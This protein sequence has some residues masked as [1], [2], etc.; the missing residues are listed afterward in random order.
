ML[1]N[2]RLIERLFG[3][4]D[5]REELTLAAAAQASLFKRR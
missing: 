3:V 1:P 2:Y 4:I 5:E